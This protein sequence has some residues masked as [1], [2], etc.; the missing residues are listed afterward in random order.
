METLRVGDP[1]RQVDRHRRHR[2]A[3]ATRAH[4]RLVEAGRAEGATSSSPKSNCRRKAASIRRRW[5]AASS[6]LRRLA[7]EEIF[8]P[9]LVAMT[10][11]TPDEAVALANNTR[12]GLAA[13][14]W[15]ENINRALEVAAQIKAGVVWIN[16]TNLF[17]A[18]AGF[19]G[20]RE[21]GFGREGGREGMAEYLKPRA[22]R[23]RR[24]AAPATPRT[25][26]PRRGRRRPRR[27]HRPHRRRCTSAA[28]R[29]GRTRGYSYS[30]LDAEG[31]LA[32]PGGAGQPQGH[33]QRGRG[34]EQG[35]RLGRRDRAQ[36]RAGALLRRREPRRRA[37]PNSPS[38]CAR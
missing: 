11:R 26:A 12:Y 4:P 10:F 19:G 38:A 21:S 14:V 28:S 27:R 34:C 24:A 33:P 9:V 35:D 30:V 25:R 37:P 20:Y 3:R 31:P 16:S 2:R 5:S 7:R 1:A 29:R 22:C 17:D 36:P 6:R 32:R 23:E 15:S 8:G 13:S 18:G